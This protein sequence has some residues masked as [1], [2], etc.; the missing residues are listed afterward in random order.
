MFICKQL[1]VWLSDG[2]FMPLQLSENW[3]LCCGILLEACLESSVIYIPQA[4]RLTTPPCF[5]TPFY[6]TD[7]AALYIIAISF[8]RYIVWHTK[9]IKEGVVV[10]LTH[11]R[12]SVQ[13]S[14]CI[15]GVL[16]PPR[17]LWLFP[18][19]ILTLYDAACLASHSPSSQDAS[20]NGP[21]CVSV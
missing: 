19:V 18:C 15:A 8:G 6:V 3:G 2:L 10:E 9:R 20:G 12:I 16:L 14:S 21:Y 13:A 5:T 17:L 4:L 7:L 11:A 1:Q